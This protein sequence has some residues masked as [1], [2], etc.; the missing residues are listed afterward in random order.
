MRERAASQSSPGFVRFWGIVAV[1]IIA[2]VGAH[3]LGIV[4]EGGIKEPGDAAQL[5]FVWLF[6]LIGVAQAVFGLVVLMLS[7]RIF[8]LLRLK[9]EERDGSLRSWMVVVFG[10]VAIGMGLTVIYVA[11]SLS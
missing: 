4:R 3:L 11:I 6:Y 1:G 2:V 9:F 8:G 5:S 10:A 7:Q